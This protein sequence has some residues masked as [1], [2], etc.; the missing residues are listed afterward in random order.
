ME[1][2]NKNCLYMKFKLNECVRIK[3]GQYI[4]LQCENISKLEW[5][6]FTVTDCI[7]AHKKTIF[8]LAIAVR[9]DWTDEL[10]RKIYNIITYAQNPKKRR[11]R[12]RRLGNVAP[13]R[14]KFI[15]DGPF[16]S[17]LESIVEKK[18][19]ILIAAGIGITPYI[20]I[21]NFLL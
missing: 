5:H 16:P 12:R 8:T 9:G 20:G 19:L 7:Y 11:Q 17:P 13:R 18:K 15:F 2:V 21:F 3:P 4:L 10:Y 6:P 1:P 14:L